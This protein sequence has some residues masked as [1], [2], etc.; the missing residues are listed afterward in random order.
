LL[1]ID[2]F[3]AIND[4]HGH[5]VGDRI[6]IELTRLIGQHLREIGVLARWGGEEFVI[7]M[8]HREAREAAHAADTLRSLVAD[9]GFPDVGAVTVPSGA[10]RVADGRASGRVRMP[11]SPDRW[12][13]MLAGDVG[14]GAMGLRLRRYPMN[15]N[16]NALDRV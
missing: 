7:L 12:G 6:L 13:R 10:A 9:R 2:D 16:P 11:R 3:K 5:L 8:P 4:T 14:A 1:D 15:R